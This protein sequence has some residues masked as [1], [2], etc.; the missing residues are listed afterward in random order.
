MSSKYEFIN[1]EYL[2]N[3]N[4]VCSYVGLDAHK[5]QLYNKFPSAININAGIDEMFVAGVNF[6][7]K[8]SLQNEHNIPTLK[9]YASETS[10]IHK[11]SDDTE[12]EEDLD[13]KVANGNI[14]LED[15]FNA[16]KIGIKFYDGKKLKLFDSNLHD[17]NPIK[18]V[19]GK[20]PKEE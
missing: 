8:V 4:T 6:A 15:L 12:I 18:V 1:N 7:K 3:L 14:I 20:L 19:T 16:F 13:F 2:K 9:A 5:K 11:Y 10:Q 17:P